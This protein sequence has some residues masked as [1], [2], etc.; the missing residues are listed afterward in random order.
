MNHINY[1]IYILI[2]HGNTYFW[3][4][5]CRFTSSYE[6]YVS[7][8]LALPQSHHHKITELLEFNIHCNFEDD[9]IPERERERERDKKCKVF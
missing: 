4:F 5:Y 2:K 9:E 1:M 6:Y 8:Y 3:M 7:Y